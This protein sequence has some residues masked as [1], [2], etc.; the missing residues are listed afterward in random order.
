[1][2]KILSII[3]ALLML[4][5][6]LMATSCS[7]NDQTE[8][9][10]EG[11]TISTEGDDS[12][13]LSVPD[14]LDYGGRDFT[15]LGCSDWGVE[16]FTPENADMGDQVSAAIV[17]RDNF[18]EEYLNVNIKVERIKGQFNDRLNFAQTVEKSVQS[19]A[20]AYDLISCY[21]LVAPSLATRGLLVDLNQT[22]YF[23][24]EKAWWP[25]FMY[26]VCTV[27]NKTYHISG[28]ASINLLYYL[29]AVLFDSEQ[30]SAY[31]ISEEDVYE[32]VDNGGWTL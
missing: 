27:N 30:M 23:N 7:N 2:K 1:M 13:I 6:C 29:Q 5:S 18:I 15:V 26:D 25:T 12:K 3:L 16:E 32:L 17:A 22:E 31:G 8:D 4:T 21:S 19:D 20:E 28:D 11:F 9:T 24:S 14:D 10:T